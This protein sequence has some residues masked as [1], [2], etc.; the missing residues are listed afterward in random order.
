MFVEQIDGEF[1][2]ILKNDMKIGKIDGGIPLIFP[3]PAKIED[4]AA[5]NRKIS[6]YLPQN[7]LGFAFNRKIS[8]YSYPAY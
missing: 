2:L 6:V 8:A 5:H 1:P 4:L 3:K 7:E